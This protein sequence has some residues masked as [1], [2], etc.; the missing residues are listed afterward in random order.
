VFQVLPV[1]VNNVHVLLDVAL[2]VLG[3]GMAQA[4]KL[5]R[6]GGAGA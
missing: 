5:W 6:D 1:A 4:G 3:G 2:I